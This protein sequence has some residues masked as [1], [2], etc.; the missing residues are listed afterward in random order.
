MSNTKLEFISDSTQA[1]RA[2]DA[3]NRELA[4]VREASRKL[5]EESVASAQETSDAWER[6]LEKLRQ[7]NDRW[8]A[9][10]EKIKAQTVGFHRVQGDLSKSIVDFTG[11]QKSASSGLDV[12]GS[13]LGK[14][15]VLAGTAA[16]AVS[17]LKT[18][19]SDFRREIEATAQKHAQFQDALT[20]DIAL[21]RDAFAGPEV[22]QFVA[23]VSG[24]MKEDARQA[25]R[26]VTA[27]GPTLSMDRRTS[28]AR[29][30]SRLAPIGASTFE[31]GKLSAQVADILP[32]YAPED[33]VD[34]ATLLS[35]EAGGDIGKIS[36][37]KMQRAI[38]QL[39]SSGAMSPEE[40]IGT[41]LAAAQGKISPD[42]LG[43]MATVVSMPGDELS[44]ARG[45]RSP[46][47]MAKRELASATGR[48]RLSLMRT[49]AAIAR[50]GMGAQGAI[51]FGRLSESDISANAD[52]VRGVTGQ[53]VVGGV[54]AGAV[55]GESGRMSFLRYQNAKL[56]EVNEE[57]SA[58][59]EAKFALIEENLRARAA[60][61]GVMARGFV[62]TGI[63]AE[64]AVRTATGSTVEGM[65][66]KDLVAGP[67]TQEQAERLIQVFE[68]NTSVQEQQ[69]RVR[70]LKN[71]DAHTE[72]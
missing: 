23:S 20:R 59:E 46:E 63:L 36:N 14:A 17:F 22:E 28:I 29:S 37:D 72:G 1:Q 44:P 52:L 6:G 38:K 65:F 21:T 13:G 33:V 60:G 69:L 4:K 41:A 19:Y 18:Q 31:I 27:E 43:Q 62:E 71:V 61:K 26:G 49:N 54:V 10:M 12:F 35:R 57:Q 48:G 24:V 11:A 64:K 47:A 45:D 2:I 53:D 68:K 16:T 70:G 5:R 30:A 39:V 8:A 9:G 3:L 55:R 15:A 51:E 32:G 58:N 7:Q 34:V 56:R 50:A 66:G 40:A 67:I 42:T 25:L